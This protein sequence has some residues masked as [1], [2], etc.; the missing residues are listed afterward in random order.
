MPVPHNNSTATGKDLCN[1][2][3]ML[4]SAQIPGL[5]S[6]ENKQGCAF[7]LP[8]QAKLVYVWHLKTKDSIK[9]WPR[10][11]SLRITELESF[12]ANLGLMGTHRRKI[13]KGW[14]QRF[15]LPIELRTHED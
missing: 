5:E 7:R 2:F 6:I 3:F 1:S 9:I 4:I 10:F 14:A 11:D 8:G 13:S 12:V 15:P